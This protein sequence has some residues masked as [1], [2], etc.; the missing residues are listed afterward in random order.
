MGSSRVMIW[1]SRVR[2][3]RSMRQAWVVDLPLPAVPETS[4][5]PVGQPGHGHDPLRDAHSL[6]VRDLKG[7][8]PDHRRQRAPLAVGAD[9]KPGQARQGKGEVVVSVPEVPCHRPVRPGV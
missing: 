6:I 7:H 5:M 2:L 9:P 1:P 3:M 8:H 4:T